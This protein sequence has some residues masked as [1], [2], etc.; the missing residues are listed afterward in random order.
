MILIRIPF[1]WGRTD[2]LGTLL[3]KA[4]R[5]TSSH[6]LRMCLLC[7]VIISEKG[8]ETITEP[9]VETKQCHFFHLSNC[10][11]LFQGIECVVLVL[12]HKILKC[13]QILLFLTLCSKSVCL[14][15]K[16]LF[17]IFSV[18]SDLLLLTQ[19]SCH[20]FLSLAQP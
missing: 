20:H 15:G 18:H 11:C 13:T 16:H 2:V 14:Y 17:C 1:Y 5:G 10:N 9:L 12:S 7:A 8:A 19:V 3:Y 4:G 6:V